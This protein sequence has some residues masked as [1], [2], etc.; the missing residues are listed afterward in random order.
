[1]K[2]NST[3]KTFYLIFSLLIISSLAIAQSPEIEWGPETELEKD[4]YN[5]RVVGYDAD[6]FYVLR[7]LGNYL[8]DNGNIHLDYYSSLTYDKESSIQV[9]LPTIEGQFSEFLDLFYLDGKLILFTTVTDT[10]K[11]MR[12]AYVQKLKNDGTLDGQPT[13]VGKLSLANSDKEKFDIRLIEDNQ[14]MVTAL[15]SFEE[16]G[17]Q[18]VVVKIFDSSL[19]L[20]VDKSLEIPLTGRNFDLTQIEYGKSGRLFLAIRAEQASTKKSVRVKKYDDLLLI[21]NT[22]TS[23]FETYT[24]VIEKY[25]A[26]DFMIKLDAD[27][28][29][30]AYGFLTPKSSPNYTGIFYNKINPKTLK[31]EI[32]TTGLFSREMI[33]EFVDKR[34]GETLDDYYRFNLKNIIFT[35]GGYTLFLAEQHFETSKTLVDPKTKA[36]EY[37]YYYNQND[38]IAACVDKDGVMKWTSR[39]PKSQQSINDNE[40]FLSFEAVPTKYGDKVKVLYMD[41]PS[42]LATNSAAD[43]K[44]M[45]RP[46]KGVAT[47]LTIYMDGTVDKVRLFDNEHIKNMFSPRTFFKL[48]NAYA[49]EGVSGKATQFG[50]LRFE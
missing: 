21:Y 25:L 3:M 17:G 38:I 27:E 11:K 10:K 6:G 45:K 9:F 40:F 1:M 16:Y 20:V 49:V 34:N 13:L 39:I 41:N 33:A 47:L 19:N 5:D 26:A 43:V 42:N 36:E 48:K 32:N 22:H 24:I 30:I 12:N 29:V 8:V 37:I 23:S 2:K 35:N 4:F 28:N 15:N 50:G 46:A 44:E 7:T 18:P 31:A 14:I